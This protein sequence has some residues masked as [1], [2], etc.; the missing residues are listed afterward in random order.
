MRTVDAFVALPMTDSFDVI[1]A[2]ENLLGGR[3]EV[4]RTPV[5]TLGPPRAF[6]LGLRL[7]LAALPVVARD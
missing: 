5:L 7:R 2:G 1:A 4:G 3:Y 6:R